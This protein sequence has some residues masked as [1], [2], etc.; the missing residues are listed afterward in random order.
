[1][2]FFA[3]LVFVI[4]AGMSLANIHTGLLFGHNTYEGDFH[5]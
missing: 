4:G 5:D 3:M 1:M 2:C